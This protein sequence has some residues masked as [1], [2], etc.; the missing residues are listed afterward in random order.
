MSLTTLLVV[1]DIPEQLLGPA[2]GPVGWTIAIIIGIGIVINPW[3][4]LFICNWRKNQ[5]WQQL[6]LWAKWKRDMEAWLQGYMTW[7]TENCACPG[8]GPGDPPDPPDWPN[9]G[10]DPDGGD[11]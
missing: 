10:W 5:Y 4:M 8:P 9:G 7:V 6:L 3:M 2:L 1:Q 11:A